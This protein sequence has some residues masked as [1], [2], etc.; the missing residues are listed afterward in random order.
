MYTIVAAKPTRVLLDVQINRPTK[1][2]SSYS[3]LRC[4]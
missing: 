2:E 1:A 4:K 3:T